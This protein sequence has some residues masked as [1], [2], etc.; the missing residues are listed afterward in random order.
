A[1]QNASAEEEEEIPT[2]AQ[3]AAAEGANAEIAYVDH[4]SAA[5]VDALMS[6]T[7][8]VNSVVLVACA[9]TGKMGAV[10]VGTLNVHY[11]DGDTV[12]ISNLKEKKL[13]ASDCKRVKILADGDLD[14]ALT[15]EANSFSLQAI[16]MIT[17]TGGHAIKLQPEI[18]GASEAPVEEAPVEEAPVEET[19]VEETPVEETPVEETPA[20]ETPAE[21]TP[22]EETDA[23]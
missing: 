20:E 9:A 5:D 6:D 8:A 4:V 23:E 18:P 7:Q 22:A 13:I 16:K 1:A 14:K 2:D 3:V 17:L 15:V 19:P 12:N 11:E 21:E 10:N